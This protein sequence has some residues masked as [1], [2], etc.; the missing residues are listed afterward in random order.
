MIKLDFSLKKYQFIMKL[1]GLFLIIFINFNSHSAYAISTQGLPS[2]EIKNP[3]DRVDIRMNLVSV[4]PVKGELEARLEFELKGIY[5]LAPTYPSQDLI[6][7]IN[8]AEQQNSHMVFLAGQPVGISSIKF[9]ITEGNPS[10]YPFDQ[11]QA[12]IAISLDPLFPN[13]KNHGTFDHHPVPLT[14]RLIPRIPGFK[15]DYKTV[16]GNSNIFVYIDINMTRSLPVKSFAVVVILILWVLALL[17]FFVAIK[18]A[19][20]GRIPEFGMLGWMGSLLFSFP[21]VRN[22]QPGVPPIGTLSD[23]L[24]LFWTETLV[25]ISLTIVGICWLKRYHRHS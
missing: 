7:N 12:R 21:F 13:D 4:D 15:I 22:S 20:S 6:L 1:M 2:V 24:S 10:N 19:K 14:F 8:S 9:N 11:H 23:F 5:K 25:V 18:V 16:E 17:A 3:S